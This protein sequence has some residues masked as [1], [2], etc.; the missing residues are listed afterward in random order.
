MAKSKTPKRPRN[1]KSR[2][3]RD[4]Q[5]KLERLSNDVVSKCRVPNDPPPIESGLDI[6]RK[7][8]LQL[9]AITSGTPAFSLGSLSEPSSYKIVSDTTS[10]FGVSLTDGQIASM[11]AAQ[12]LGY[13]GSIPGA[14]VFAL[15]KVA[16]WGPLTDSNSRVEL[17]IVAASTPF[18][19][20]EYDHGTRMNRAKLALSSARLRW[21]NAASTTTCIN[22]EIGDLASFVVPT[23]VTTMGVVHLTVHM[24]AQAA[25]AAIPDA[26]RDNQVKVPPREGLKK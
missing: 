14:M 24:R 20:R 7:I 6:V 25:I 4:L 9:V 5:R 1:R 10:G 17:A 15:K 8:E 22:I 26:S 3:L 19:E 23:V 13:S 2:P 11:F 18:L 16:I 21:F 12:V